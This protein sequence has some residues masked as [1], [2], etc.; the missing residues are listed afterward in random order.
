MPITGTVGVKRGRSSLDCVVNVIIPF[1]GTM[2]DD[3]TSDV[4]SRNNGAC[5]TDK[6]QHGIIEHLCSTIFHF[7]LLFFQ[8]QVQIMIIFLPRNKNGYRCF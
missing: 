8:I 2:Y 5:S 1:S 6:T 7:N 3:V 4:T